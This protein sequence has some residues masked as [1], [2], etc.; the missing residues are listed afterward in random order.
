MEEMMP[1]M[2]GHPA[3]EPGIEF[4]ALFD[5]QEQAFGSDMYLNFHTWGKGK[6]KP[7]FGLRLRDVFG[8]LLP[9]A[10]EVEFVIACNDLTFFHF[11]LLQSG[12]VLLFRPCA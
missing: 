11:G 12:L 1:D 10:G 5:I 9:T 4:V 3:L 2:R 7:P 6:T 8:Q